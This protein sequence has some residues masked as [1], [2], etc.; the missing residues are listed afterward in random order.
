MDLK[1][2]SRE[3]VKEAGLAG[4]LMLGARRVRGGLTG[5]TVK[6]IEKRMGEAAGDMSSSSQ[7]LLGNLGKRLPKAKAF[8]RNVRIGT[9]LAAGGVVAGRM[10]KSDNGG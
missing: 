8:Q 1:T 9:G 10:S 7:N 3:L 6:N 4:K 5:S 2:F